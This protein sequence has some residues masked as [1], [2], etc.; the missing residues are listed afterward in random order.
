M[1][2]LLTLIFIFCFIFCCD[3][4]KGPTGPEGQHGKTGET[5]EKGDTGDTGNTGQKG[6]Q[7]EPGKNLEFIIIDGKLAPGDPEYWV[8]ETISDLPSCFI[9]V[10]VSNV[11]KPTWWRFWDEIWIIND[12]LSDSGDEYRIIIASEPD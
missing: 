5:G 2:N 1:K 3:S 8:I 6:E 12:E 7:G 11:I 10:Y 9:S 4:L